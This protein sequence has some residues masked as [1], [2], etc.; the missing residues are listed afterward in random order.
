MSPG[1]GRKD[2]KEDRLDAEI[3][4]RVIV[5]GAGGEGMMSPSNQVWQ[6]SEKLKGAE[7]SA[8]G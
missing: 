1:D 7:L 5:P 4:M 2:E 6:K 3:G 8:V